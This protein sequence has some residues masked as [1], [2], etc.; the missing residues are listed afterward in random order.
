[1]IFLLGLS[2]NDYDRIVL[3]LDL[4]FGGIDVVRRT[5]HGVE[6]VLVVEAMHF[7]FET[8]LQESRFDVVRVDRAD[9][10]QVNVDPN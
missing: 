4:G 9:S 2:E 5:R 6:I 1:M 3:D 10:W 7:H 8:I